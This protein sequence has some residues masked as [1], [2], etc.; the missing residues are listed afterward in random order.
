MQRYNFVLEPTYTAFGRKEDW[1]AFVD[2]YTDP[3]PLNGVQW[4]TEV[5]LAAFLG[6]RPDSG[7]I[8]A[9][10]KVERLSD[11]LVVTVEESQNTHGD[12]PIPSTPF[13]LV[14]VKR[15]DLRARPLTVVF[16]DPDGNTL[17]QAID[18]L[19]SLVSSQPGT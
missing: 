8:V 17:G 16:V 18:A 2:Q 11:T 1:S 3:M 15:A 19:S 10:V 14:A 4:S 6:E 12:A 13:H 7:T 9:I 5:V